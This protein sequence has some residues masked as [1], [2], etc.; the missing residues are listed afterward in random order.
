MNVDR[1]DLVT[2]RLDSIRNKISDLRP[3]LEEIGQYMVR[4][5]QHRIVRSKTSPDGERWADNSDLTVE[6]KGRNSPLYHTG[7]LSK[8]VRVTKLDANRVVVSATSPYASHN[9]HGVNR[10]RGKYRSNRPP[11]Q[12][13]A[14]P[15]MGLSDANV[16]RIT[17]I[18]N[19][20]V[21]GRVSQGFSE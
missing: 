1:L 12:V 17:K 2:R 14:R 6:L 18:V 5:T 19:D 21:M 15:F 7:N 11:K 13:S 16:R 4:S 20:Y 9:Q 8:S 10:V 3:V